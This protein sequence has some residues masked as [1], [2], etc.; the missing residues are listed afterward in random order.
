MGE[1][2]R[3]GMTAFKT[4]INNYQSFLQTNAKTGKLFKKGFQFSKMSF[5]FPFDGLASQK[6]TI[7]LKVGENCF[8]CGHFLLKNAAS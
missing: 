4:A 5:F 7:F 6:K 2:R 3:D 1:R 8:C